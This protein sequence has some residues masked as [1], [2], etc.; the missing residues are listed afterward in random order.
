MKETERNLVG[1]ASLVPSGERERLLGQKGA[2][3]WF[4]GLSGSGKSTLSRGLEKALIEAGHPAYVLDGDNI[5][6]GLNSDLG[7]SSEDRTENIRRVAEVANLL[8]DAGLIAITAFISPFRADRA[9]ARAIIRSPFLEVH[10]AADLSVCESRDAKGLYKKARAGGVADF[11]GIS[12]PYEPPETPD[13]RLDTAGNTVDAGVEEI[14]KTLR[15]RGILP[16]R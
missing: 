5:R 9:A 2:V 16:R 10:C 7:F 14:L 3:V 11:T 8:A 1:S 6:M 12:S 13:L 4:T 15:A